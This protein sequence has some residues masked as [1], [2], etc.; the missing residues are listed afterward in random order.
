MSRKWISFPLREGEYS[1][2]AHCDFPA[3]TYEREMG[4]RPQPAQR[5]ELVQPIEPV[6]SAAQ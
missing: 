3:D 2:Q 4:I 6:S 5:P 1:R